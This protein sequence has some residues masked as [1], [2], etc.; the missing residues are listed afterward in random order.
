MTIIGLERERQ[1]K[2]RKIEKKNSWERERN[3]KKKKKR[4]RLGLTQQK[5]LHFAVVKQK[6]TLHWFKV[7]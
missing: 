6:Y 4:N 7:S 3:S 5:S 1:R 2:G